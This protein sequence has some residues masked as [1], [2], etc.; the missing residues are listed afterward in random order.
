MSAKLR[1][2][3]FFNHVRY[4]LCSWWMWWRFWG[5]IFLQEGLMG[6]IVQNRVNR[7]IERRKEK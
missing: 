4:L 2:K 1:L 7:E 6:V 3:L 5:N